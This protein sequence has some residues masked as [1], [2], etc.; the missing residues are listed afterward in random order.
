MT[1]P[2]PNSATHEAPTFGWDTVFALPISRVNMAIVKQK[3][4]PAKLDYL[5]PNTGFNLQVDFGD[6]QIVPEGDGSII[7]LQ[8]PMRN[9]T[10]SFRDLHGNIE[11]I[12]CPQLSG[13]VQIKLQFFEHDDALLPLNGPDGKP[14]PPPADGTT[15]HKLM[16][17]TTSDDPSDPVAEFISIACQ[18][19]LVP[20]TAHALV[21][22]ALEEWCNEHL[23]E[24]AH[25]F[26]IIDLNDE[27]ASGAFAFCKPHTTSYAYID[28]ST[29]DS[30][31]LAVLCMTSNDPEPTVQ[32]AS[33]FAIPAL[34]EA[35]F[36][37]SPRR[38][39]LDMV[40]PSLAG[41]WP[42]LPVNSLNIAPGD[43]IL[44][45]DANVSFE[46]PEFTTDDGDTYTPTMS[47]FC[48]EIISDVLKID[49]YTEVNVSPGVYATCTATHWYRIKLGTNKSG[50]QTLIYEEA[51]T[52]SIS[53][54]SR[55]DEGIEILKL[56]L[57]IMAVVLTAFAIVLTGGAALVVGVALVCVLVGE[58][59]VTNIE[60]SHQDDAPAMDMLTLNAAAPII[61]S[62]SQ[63]F[64]LQAAGL[65]ASL[66]LGGIWH[67]AD[68]N[69]A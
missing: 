42:K 39:L 51:Q 5:N 24:F 22:S 52:P 23:A 35:G 12:S 48:I 11:Q 20:A 41:V 6:W 67:A 68:Q 4:S 2:T 40:K 31:V 26:A 10:G 64:T 16:P 66:Q 56:V 47:K 1:D 54:G 36:L 53:K 17:K 46:L 13:F 30:S 3:A 29:P 37:I 9:L 45:L 57:E 69:T 65:N 43:K 63:D 14:L 59:I 21:E 38:F 19:P 50:R 49:T 61:W 58:F 33:N 18:Q 27:I 8:L 15:R 32:Q 55:H 25:I 44:Q 34:C 28:H 60:T 7:R 62:D